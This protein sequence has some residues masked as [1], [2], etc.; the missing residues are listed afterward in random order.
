MI[1]IYTPSDKLFNYAEIEELYNDCKELIGDDEFKDVID[2]TLFFAFYDETE[3]IGCIYYYKLA[4][5]LMYVNAFAHRK[6]HELN[7]E[8]FKYSLSWFD[9]DIYAKT[10]HRTAKLCLLRTGFKEVKKGLYKYIRSKQYG[11]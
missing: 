5:S 4:D 10:Q 7:L 11:R 2:R 1:H 8:C 9:C 6:H 3:L